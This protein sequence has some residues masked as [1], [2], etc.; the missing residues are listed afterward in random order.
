[1]DTL[2]KR[3]TEAPILAN[4]DPDLNTEV[5][6]DASYTA[7]EAFLSQRHGKKIIVVEYAS[8][9]VPETDQHKHSTDLE[10]IAAH[11][12]ITDCFHAYFQG[13]EHFN[14]YTDNWAVMHIISKK[15]PQRFAWIILDLAS[16]NFTIHQTPGESSV[17]LRAPG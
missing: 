5:H 4:F 6:V 14:L 10:A 2:K 9:K 12:A 7:F 8:K 1:M 17:S 15:N 11:W 16:Y 3:L 13:L